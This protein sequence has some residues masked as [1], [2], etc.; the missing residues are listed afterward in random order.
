MTKY[1]PPPLVTTRQFSWDEMV[2]REWG[3]EYSAP[4][5]RVYVFGER[6]YDSTDRGTTGIYR[7]KQGG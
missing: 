6:A 7:P 1:N 4:D 3:S 5:H 2:R